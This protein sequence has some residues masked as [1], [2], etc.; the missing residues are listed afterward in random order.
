M[1]EQWLLVKRGLYYGPNNS[2]YTGIKDLAGRY[3][4]ED[5][6]KILDRI[7]KGQFLTILFLRV[8]PIAPSSL[9]NLAAGSGKIPF[10]RF[11]AATIIGMT[12]GT[13][14]LVVFQKSLMDVFRKPGFFSIFTLFIL[15]LSTFIIFRWS[16]KRFSQYRQH[17]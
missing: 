4:Y 3:D 5:A 15:A 7:G 14:M 8:F 6:K 1:G 10:F 17:S 11:L 16:R 2:G 9:I 12:P 13:I